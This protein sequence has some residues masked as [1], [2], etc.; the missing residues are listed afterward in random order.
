MFNITYSLSADFLVNPRK[1]GYDYV[2]KG[3]FLL[4][5]E[6]FLRNE[7]FIGGSTLALIF[8]KSWFITA[9]FHSIHLRAYFPQVNV[10]I[11]LIVFYWQLSDQF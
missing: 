9:R 7:H 3:T 1:Y 6:D 11:A 4:R 10:T 5:K 2:A 8:R